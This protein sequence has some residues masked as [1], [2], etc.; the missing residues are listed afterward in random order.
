V[1]VLYD[2]QAFSMQ[3]YGGVSRYVASVVS[4][5]RASGEDVTAEFAGGYANNEFLAALGE[6]Q[7]RTLLHRRQ[8]RGAGTLQAAAD[9]LN[10]RLVERRIDAGGIDVAHPTY[11]HTVPRERAAGPAVVLTV[12]DMIHELFDL[13]DGERVRALKRSAVERSD[14][15]VAV[16]EHTAH[17]L[18]ELLGVPA[19]KIAVIP[20]GR[21]FLG[22][23]QGDESLATPERFVLYVGSR[24][25][26]KNFARLAEAL[27]PLMADDPALA[28]VCAG[29]GPLNADETALADRFGLTGRIVSAPADD[30]SLVT[31]YR[32]ATLFC[33]PSRYEGFGLPLLEAMS[34][35]CPAVASDASSLPEVGGDAVRYVDPE[36]AG[37]MTAVIDELLGD[38]GARRSLTEAGLAR[39]S[40]FSWEASAAAHIA[41]YRAASSAS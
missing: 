31:L 10:A 34:L 4:A 11:Y 40:R 38:E 30:A 19:E 22:T 41:L 24:T 37:S 21:T 5:I 12:H 36:S 32:R 15:I 27:A 17:D 26:Y 28:L 3:R 39:A 7:P 16:S 1:R 14:R 6:P 18:R 13:P 33:C 35:G 25:G 9:L 23:E 29:G 8:G 20:H 2:Y